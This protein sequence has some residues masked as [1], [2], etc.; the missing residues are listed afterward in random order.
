MYFV[1]GIGAFLFHVALVWAEG[2]V[3]PAP[4]QA[5]AAKQV[6][7]SGFCNALEQKD[8]RLA[9]S[10]YDQGG[11]DLEIPCRESSAL[12]STVLGDADIR[13]LGTLISLLANSSL[14][15]GRTDLEDLQFI[16]S[17]YVKAVGGPNVTTE[18]G[19]PLIWQFETEIVAE[20]KVGNLFMGAGI[21]LKL[22]VQA[23]P[24]GT[25]AF[26]EFNSPLSDQTGMTFLMRLCRVD[27]YRY[28]FETAKAYERNQ[29]RRDSI[30]ALLGEII[31]KSPLAAQDAY[32]RTALHHCALFGNVN[33]TKEIVRA[34]ADSSQKDAA[35]L[36]PIDYA[37]ARGDRDL[38]VFQPPVDTQVR[39]A[40]LPTSRPVEAAFSLD[41]SGSAEDRLAAAKIAIESGQF[42]SARSILAALAQEGNA[43]AMYQL[44]RL[45]IRGEGGA[46]SFDEARKLWER[47]A[48]AEHGESLVALAKLYVYGDG[49]S[50]SEAVAK[51]YLNRA[52]DAGAE[53]PTDL[54]K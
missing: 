44:G 1:V 47:A 35:G 51:M 34:G 45:V 43:P 52:K 21:D 8:F 3:T 12:E 29:E 30:K 42:G 14:T 2:V 24:Y 40:P 32:G 6:A 11:V 50:K 13:A 41:L 7:H 49:V 10:L 9:R 22:A 5:S 48:D 20:P 17:E 26:K 15:D 16:I 36:L 23:P 53:I 25:K 46:Q 31:S 27:D 54:V 37:I 4:P 39:E 33:L 19:T 38:T 18:N 28:A